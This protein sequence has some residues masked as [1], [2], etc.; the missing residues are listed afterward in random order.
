MSEMAALQFHH[1]QSNDVWLWQCGMHTVCKR[2]EVLSVVEWAE[3]RVF[4][5]ESEEG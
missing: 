1:S 4:E 5:F 3:G 2:R